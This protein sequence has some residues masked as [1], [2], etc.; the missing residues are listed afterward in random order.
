MTGTGTRT[1]DNLIQTYFAPPSCSRHP[2]HQEPHVRGMG[3]GQY[4]DEV[5]EQEEAT[6][7]E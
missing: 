1:T 4:G 2:L 6:Q 7:E 3:Y 5:A